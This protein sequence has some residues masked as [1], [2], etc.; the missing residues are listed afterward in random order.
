MERGGGMNFLKVVFGIVLCI[1]LSSCGPVSTTA[2]PDVRV[3]RR[4][5]RNGVDGISPCKRE[6]GAVA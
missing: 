1:S 4:R 6:G 2:T 5:Y 3:Y